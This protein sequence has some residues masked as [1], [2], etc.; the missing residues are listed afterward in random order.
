MNNILSL[1]FNITNLIYKNPYKAR[2]NK[3]IIQQIDKYYIKTIYVT[4]NE[5]DYSWFWEYFKDYN[6][7]SDYNGIYFC[8]KDKN[9]IAPR[10]LYFDYHLK[11]NADRSL[12]LE[13][14]SDRVFAFVFYLFILFTAIFNLL[15]YVISV[16]E[17]NYFLLWI[18][19][20]ILLWSLLQCLVF[21]INH[22]R[23]KLLINF[24]NK[25]ILK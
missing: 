9:S 18:L 20:Y 8:L 6:V 24:I 2:W 1:S 15:S 11:I 25:F 5:P 16:F 10:A 17:Q 12:R 19:V 14:N 23:Y 22:R 4:K 3:S 13:I 7:E 21:Q